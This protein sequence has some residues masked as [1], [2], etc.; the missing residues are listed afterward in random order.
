MVGGG[1][2]TGYSPKLKKS[3]VDKKISNV[4]RDLP[5]SP[6]QTLKS[7]DDWFI[8]ILKNKVKKPRKSET[9]LK[10]SRSDQILWF[11][12]GERVMY[13]AVHTHTH[14]N[15]GANNVMLQFCL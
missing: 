9:N 8:R 6:R 12:L 5:V 11:K 7:A 4:L 15:A 14:I 3:F 2:L 10:K 1:G 13:H